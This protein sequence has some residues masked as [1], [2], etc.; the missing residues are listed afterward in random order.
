MQ[1]RIPSRIHIVDH[2]EYMDPTQ[3]RELDHAHQGPVCPET[4]TV[5]DLV[6]I[7]YPS[8]VRLLAPSV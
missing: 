5:R 4:S 1:D 3:P 8:D 2:A 7:D 6:R